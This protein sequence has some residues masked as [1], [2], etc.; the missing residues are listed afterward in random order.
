MWSY[1]KARQQ[2][3]FFVFIMKIRIWSHWPSMSV[4]MVTW[5][6]N[7]ISWYYEYLSARL[8]YFPINRLTK[9]LWTAPHTLL[10]KVISVGWIY[11]AVKFNWVSYMFKMFCHCS[12]WGHHQFTD[13]LCAKNLIFSCH[14]SPP[15]R[16]NHSMNTDPATSLSAHAVGVSVTY[17]DWLK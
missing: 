9:S 13:P 2:A 7:Q 11:C 15:D 14:Q 5:R 1:I 16:H 8:L 17:N 4:N 6:H 3:F 12:T 10:S